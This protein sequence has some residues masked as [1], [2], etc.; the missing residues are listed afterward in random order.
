MPNISC[1]IQGEGEVIL[2]LHGWGQ[3]KEMMLPLI[4]ELKYH[5]KCVTLD[6]PGFGKSEFFS[7]SNFDE[8]VDNIRLFLVEQRILPKY[9]VG[10]S[11]GGKVAVNYYLKYKDLSKLII[12]ASPI[13]KPTRTLKYYYKVYKYKLKNFLKLKNNNS[14]SEDYRNC[15]L[16]MR[17]FFVNTV[18]KHFDKRINEIKIP[19][20]LIWGDNDNKVPLKKAKKLNRKLSNSELFIEKGS[21]FAYL[22]DI[23][24]TRLIIQKFLRRN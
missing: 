13:L 4:E 19:T 7:V 12:I 8:Y 10:H 23:E 22:E 20:L 14:G 3:N 9:I 17:S 2:F 21:H 1:D 15:S 16:K 11:F 5:Y 24:L 18:N 6:L